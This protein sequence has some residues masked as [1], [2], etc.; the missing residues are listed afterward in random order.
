MGQVAAADR[1]IA[2]CAAARGA[3]HALGTVSAL[4]VVLRRWKVVGRTVAVATLHERNRPA[5]RPSMRQFHEASAAAV[6]APR[7]GMTALEE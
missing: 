4:A 2:G 7:P 1:P 3:G 5:P 6:T